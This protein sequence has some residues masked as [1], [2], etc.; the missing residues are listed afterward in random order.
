MIEKLQFIAALLMAAID[1]SWRKLI[2]I[3]K[4]LRTGQVVDDELKA[5]RLAACRECPLFFRPLATCGYPFRDSGC[6]CWMPLK[7]G[8]LA[9]CWAYDEFGNDRIIG[10][11]EELNSIPHEQRD[12]ED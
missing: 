2:G 7:A 3:C 12:H 10:W 6:H 4:A 9:N 11:P 8:Q 5:K 1:D